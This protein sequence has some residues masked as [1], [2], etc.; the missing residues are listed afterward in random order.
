MP[1]FRLG[2]VPVRLG[3]EPLAQGL[4]QV[5]LPE[6]GLDRFLAHEYGAT[7]AIRLDGLNVAI[8]GQHELRLT[9]LLLLSCRRF[10]IGLPDMMTG[11]A[12]Q[13]RIVVNTPVATKRKNR[14]QLDY[15]NRNKAASVCATCGRATDTCWLPAGNMPV[16][17]V[18]AA[19]PDQRLF[20]GS[21][22]ASSRFPAKYT[23]DDRGCGPLS[24][25]GLAGLSGLL[26]NG[27][28][29]RGGTQVTE[30]HQPGPLNEKG[31]RE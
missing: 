13:A 26:E 25:A 27:G 17:T 20:P 23:S 3:R 8:L 28:A 1:A 4:L 31:E 29:R 11:S 9:R 22:Q 18:R 2:L 19:S 5:D 30:Y 7:A 10:D 24:V 12:R 21:S 6:Q 16:D 14:H 15:L